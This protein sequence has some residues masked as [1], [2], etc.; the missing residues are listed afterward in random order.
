MQR[1]KVAEDLIVAPDAVEGGL[2]RPTLRRRMGVQGGRRGETR[3]GVG[4]RQEEG[5]SALYRRLGE[6]QVVS[7][8]GN[9]RER[10]ARRRKHRHVERRRWGNA[11]D[12]F[13]DTPAR[14]LADETALDTSSAGDE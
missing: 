9:I 2:G 5:L 1:L 14:A 10:P 3:R 12:D 8:A 6:E 4:G 11:E 7:Q 13:D